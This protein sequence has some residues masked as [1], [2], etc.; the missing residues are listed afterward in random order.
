[1]KRRKRTNSKVPAKG[2]LR[3]MAGQLWALAVKQD[4]AGRCAVCGKR[5]CQAHHLLSRR[6]Q[7]VRYALRNGIALCATHHTLGA[8]SAH[9]NGPG[10][11][12]WLEAEHPNVVA[13]LRMVTETDC[14]RFAGITNAAYYIEQI[15]RLREYVEPEDF[16][17]IVGIRFAAYLDSSEELK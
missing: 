12:F 13:W 4:W 14:R 9:E 6:H 2:R 10:F 11:M 3:D 1:M 8:D 16:E 5:K 7:A 17:R 15:C